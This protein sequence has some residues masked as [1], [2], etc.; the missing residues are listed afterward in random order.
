MAMVGL[1]ASAAPSAP[2]GVAASGG[3]G[4][5]GGGGGVGAWMA[6]QI[7]RWNAYKGQQVAAREA[8]A[9]TAVA[10]AT[11]VAAT[12]ALE[13]ACTHATTSLRASAGDE[14]ID[15]LAEAIRVAEAAGV[16]DGHVRAARRRLAELEGRVHR[17]KQERAT[18]R[19]G[20]AISTLEGLV[21][22]RADSAGASDHGALRL[23][24]HVYSRHPPKKPTI[25]LETLRGI[26]AEK[27]TAA[28]AGGG[29][30]RLERT[31]KALLKA[32]RDYHPDRNRADQVGVRETLGLH[33]SEEWEVL[34]LH[35]CQQAGRAYELLK[36]AR[37]MARDSGEP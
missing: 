18:G 20:E 31:K 30:H 19:L 23:L 10:S 9:A 8:A 37:D 22:D 24:L 6:R 29:G 11:M 7:D 4:G 26:G 2:K 1:G 36:G 3:W 25:T 15:S 32:Q 35:I 34:C 28:E 21:V 27:G 13:L 17:A 14:A 16:D 5:G 12:S 33:S